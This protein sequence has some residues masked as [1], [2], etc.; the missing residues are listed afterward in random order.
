[1]DSKLK[2]IVQKQEKLIAGFEK[3]C[4]ADQKLIDSQKKLILAQQEELSL[5]KKEKQALMDAGNELSAANETLEKLCREQQELL[6]SFSNI[7]SK[8]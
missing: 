7:L 8:P 2:Q 5:L 1:M 4:T 3:Q 6:T